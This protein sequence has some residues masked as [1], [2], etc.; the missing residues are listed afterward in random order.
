MNLLSSK[1]EAKSFSIEELHASVKRTLQPVQKRLEKS[2]KNFKKVPEDVKCFLAATQQLNHAIQILQ[3]TEKI[4]AK[5]IKLLDKSQDLVRELSRRIPYPLFLNCLKM[6]QTET[7][8]PDS[9]FEWML[10]LGLIMKIYQRVN[11][12]DLKKEL[13]FLAVN[14]LGKAAPYSFA[15]L[16]LPNSLKKTFNSKFHH[17]LIEPGIEYNRESPIFDTY[18]SQYIFDHLASNSGTYLFVIGNYR[19][20]DLLPIWFS[21]IQESWAQDIERVIRPHMD[22]LISTDF[23]DFVEPPLV[24]D[25]TSILENWLYTA[26]NEKKN[27]KFLEQLT[28]I[29]ELADEAVQSAAHQLMESYPDNF[30]TEEEKHRF[31]VYL[32][33]NISCICR[34]H[35]KGVGFIKIIPLFDRNLFALP[36]NTPLLTTVFSK[37]TIESSRFAH[38]LWETGLIRSK[39]KLN[40]FI[41]GTGIRMSCIEGREALL[42]F[43]PLE[44]IVAVNHQPLVCYTISGPNEIYYRDPAEI[45]E[46]ALFKRLTQKLHNGEFPY[47]KVL[48][49]STIKLIKG[50]FAEIDLTKWKNLNEHPDLRQV[51][52]NTLIGMLHHLAKMENHSDQFGP[53]TLANEIVHQKMA[54]LLRLFSPFH[55]EDFSGLYLQRNFIIPDDLR[56]YVQAGL[57][58]TSMNALA[59]VNAALRKIVDHPCRVYQWAAH[60]EIVQ[61]MGRDLSLEEAL[62]DGEDPIHLYVCDINHNICLLEEIDEYQASDVKREIESL[63]A[64]RPQTQRLTVALDS[65]IDLENSKQ[66]GALLTHFTPEILKGI[67]NFVIF[68]SGQ[69]FD[70]FGLD[71]Y[72]GAP[73]YMI[74]ND[75]PCW[76]PFEDLLNNDLY[77]TDLLSTQWFCLVNKYAPKYQDL[78][79]QLIFENT[80]FIL[81]GIPNHLMPGQQPD[82]KVCT[83]SEKMNPCFIDIKVMG[84]SARNR[85][86]QIIQA[87]YQKF[88]DQQGKIHT[89]GGYGFYHPNISLFPFLNEGM[90]IRINPGIDRRESE[91]ILEVFKEMQPS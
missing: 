68:R 72:Y 3:E 57:T 52:Q 73:F 43:M 24:L 42:S 2:D 40:D 86:R 88:A 59:A 71:H 11:D 1:I 78:Y 58:K 15:E 36:V 74:H 64:A 37:H 32:R 20:D 80:R 75:D 53:F 5:T 81:N 39:A 29:K 63:L 21:M 17:G 19:I 54:V 34:G 50:L 38:A 46:I 16:S 56:P 10:H 65:T 83:V 48:G 70:M 60:F 18:L 55:R 25:L 82:I 12:P 47:L 41:N 90:S 6:D 23:E 67:L 28:H 66:I 26:G 33:A 62:K 85:A 35:L 44:E 8:I 76:K 14:Y 77:K 69:K 89:R 31:I 27:R 84:E 91:L 13:G 87:F 61:G 30:Q 7:K 79:R 22:K 4:P 51:L 49:L 9:H 45:A